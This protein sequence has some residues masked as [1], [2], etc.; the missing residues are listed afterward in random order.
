[1]G[2]HPRVFRNYLDRGFCAALF[3][4][5][6][7]MARLHRLW[8]AAAG[9]SYELF[10]VPN[11]NYEQITGPRHLTIFGGETISV[12]Q[13]V[14]N[15]WIKVSELSSLFLLLF[16]VD[17][18]VALWRRGHR[19]ERRRAVVVGG[20]MTFFILVAAGTSALIEA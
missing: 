9:P 5:R 4:G 6:A 19:G 12:A 16:V 11:L 7:I 14:E 18:S 10:S 17:A 3:Q 13:G 8:P 15:P 20:S 2:A 1:M